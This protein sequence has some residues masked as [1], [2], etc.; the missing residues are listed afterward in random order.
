MNICSVVNRPAGTLQCL[1]DHL[2]VSYSSCVCMRVFIFC[3]YFTRSCVEDCKV[4]K[5]KGAN[6]NVFRRSC[7]M[8]Y[9]RGAYNETIYGVASGEI[10]VCSSGLDVRLNGGL[11]EAETRKFDC[12]IMS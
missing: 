9:D 8:N 1:F 2:A 3:V 5:G 4:V 10:D 11:K 7:L 6:M 12:H